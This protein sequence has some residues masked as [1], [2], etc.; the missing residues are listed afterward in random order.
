M[1][2]NINVILRDRRKE[3][4]YTLEYVGD[5]MGLAK[6]TILRWENGEIS[7]IKLFQ[8]KA[9]CEILHLDYVQMLNDDQQL[10]IEDS[11][12]VI[13]RD[14][15]KTKLDQIETVNQ[16]DQVDTFIDAFILKK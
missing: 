10:V 16:L 3:L 12:V 11:E 5:K 6:S 8:L 4:G 7:K 13:K 14:K 1:R 9:L 2:E 15:I